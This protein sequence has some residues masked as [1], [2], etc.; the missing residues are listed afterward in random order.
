[1]TGLRDSFPTGCQPDE[2]WGVSKYR[3]P[4]GACREKVHLALSNV[5]AGR[6]NRS[7]SIQRNAGCT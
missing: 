6:D 4:W 2:L 7:L 3:A 1:M 5:C